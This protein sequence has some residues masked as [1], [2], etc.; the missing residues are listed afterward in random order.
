MCRWPDL[1][2][3]GHSY[4]ILTIFCLQTAA[5][6]VILSLLSITRASYYSRDSMPA[7]PPD[8]TE[9][10]NLDLLR[11]AV[12]LIHSK[13]NLVPEISLYKAPLL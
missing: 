10:V 3:L 9:R 2:T 1:P 5:G 6:A 8:S 7:R 11:L 4:V 12:L 13:F